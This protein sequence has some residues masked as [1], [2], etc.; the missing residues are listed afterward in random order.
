M[1]NSI[2]VQ[3]RFRSHQSQPRVN[4][5]FSIYKRENNPSEQLIV[6]EPLITVSCDIGLWSWFF[7]HFHFEHSIRQNGDKPGASHVPNI[8]PL[9]FHKKSIWQ[10]MKKTKLKT[11]HH[12]AS[13][14]IVQNQQEDWVFQNKKER[15]RK[16][17]ELTNNQS[18]YFSF[19]RSK[20]KGNNV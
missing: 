10:E 13:L 3:V 2:T 12:P 15:N 9:L 1:I 18:I 8:F 20:E 16:R 14:T 7:L 6:Q 11:I 5:Q 17:M 4:I 19:S